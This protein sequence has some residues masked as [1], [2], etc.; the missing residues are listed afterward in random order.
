MAVYWQVVE[1][2]TTVLEKEIMIQKHN[3]IANLFEKGEQKL[4]CSLNSV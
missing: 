3:N 2:T 1:Q 4:A